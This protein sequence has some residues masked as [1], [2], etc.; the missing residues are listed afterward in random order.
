M[1]SW[2]MKPLFKE[3]EFVIVKEDAGFESKDSLRY[4]P[5]EMDKYRGK[6]MRIKNILYTESFFRYTLE[7]CYEKRLSGS[8]YWWKWAEEWL[9]PLYENNINDISDKELIDLFH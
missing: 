4:I 8:V 9:E 5:E 3:N 7:D 6:V 2:E 1:Y